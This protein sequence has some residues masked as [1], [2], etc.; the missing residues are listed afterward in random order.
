MFGVLLACVSAFGQPAALRGCIGT[1]DRA[2]RLP[3]GRMNIPK[4]LA[5]LADL[6]A[7]TY[8]FLIGH[9]TND[10][11]D[12]RAFLPRAR[13]QGLAVWVTLL[14]PSESPPR[15]KQFS[16]PFRLDFERWAGELARLS[17]AETNLVAW[18]IDDFFH[19]EAF[20]TPDYVKRYTDLARGI[21]PRLH[22][23][24][25]WYFRQIK[26]AT[27]EKYRGLFDGVLFPYRAESDPQ[28]NLTNA[29]R[30]ET[31]VQIIRR[32]VGTN[33]PVV[34]DVYA[35]AHSRL[36][37]STPEYVQAVVRRGLRCCDG[38]LIFCHQDPVAD[39]AKYRVIRTE[40]HAW[41]RER[42]ARSDGDATRRR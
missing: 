31:E 12:L 34:L 30:V 13:E 33:V 10:W 38:V 5:E 11:D 42:A 3:D 7:N 37:G 41:L 19:N 4:L 14:P 23:V 21:N 8:N 18:S 39:A 6:R 2:P 29:T 17:L 15:G 26:P 36:G 22:S 27:A 25:C 35:T 40:F 24:P 1:Y 9:H 20:F 28:P 32:T 16:E